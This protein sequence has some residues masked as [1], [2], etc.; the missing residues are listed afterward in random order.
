[1]TNYIDQL[2]G[3][4]CGFLPVSLDSHGTNVTRRESQRSVSRAASVLERNLSTFQT[5]ADLLL[6]DSYLLYRHIGLLEV[7]SLTWLGPAVTVV[8]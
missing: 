2:W 6:A 8:P 3:H 1:M 5:Y 4:H 7:S